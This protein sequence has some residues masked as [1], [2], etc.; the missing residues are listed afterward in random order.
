[1]F[2]PMP[3]IATAIHELVHLKCVKAREDVWDGQMLIIKGGD[4]VTCPV[5]RQALECGAALPV[6]IALHLP[7]HEMHVLD[8]TI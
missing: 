3:E 7:G 8:I 5:L 6:R 1:M 2:D 4:L